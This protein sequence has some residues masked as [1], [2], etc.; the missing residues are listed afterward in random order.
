MTVIVTACAAFGLTV[1]KATTEIVCLQTKNGGN[2][3]FT[4]TAS[5]QVYK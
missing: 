3:R 5:G 1:S 2:V 4:V